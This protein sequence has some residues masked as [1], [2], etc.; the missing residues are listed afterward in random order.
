MGKVAVNTRRNG[1]DLAR[2]MLLPRRHISIPMRKACWQV[3]WGLSRRAGTTV[4][5]HALECSG[6]F[7]GAMTRTTQR[8]YREEVG[9]AHLY[10]KRKSQPREGTGELSLYLRY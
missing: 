8:Q 4:S 3:L 2:Y 7:L 10:G 6:M 1:R 5:S 9:I